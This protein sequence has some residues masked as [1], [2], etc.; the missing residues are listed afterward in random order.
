[1]CCCNSISFLRYQHPPPARRCRNNRSII[2][3]CVLSIR[4]HV[5]ILSPPSSSRSYSSS[6][7]NRHVRHVKWSIFQMPKPQHYQFVSRCVWCSQGNLQS[8]R[9]EIALCPLL[10]QHRLLCPASEWWVKFHHLWNIFRNKS[11]PYTRSHIDTHTYTH[12]HR[13]LPV[14]ALRWVRNSHSLAGWFSLCFDPV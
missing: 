6:F 2:N 10:R 8:P 5:F 3:N 1:M 13:R 11:V 4:P 14:D 12:T 9:P 7:T